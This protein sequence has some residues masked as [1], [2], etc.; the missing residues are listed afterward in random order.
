MLINTT[1]KK[2]ES[3]EANI[4]INTPAILCYIYKKG[5]KANLRLHT[6]TQTL[7]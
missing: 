2:M 4:H 1:A 3:V 7:L 6:H 5:E